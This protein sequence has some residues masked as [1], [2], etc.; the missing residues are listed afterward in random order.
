MEIKQ[1][2]ERQESDLKSLFRF[3]DICIFV[4]TF[5]YVE[6]RLDKK[7]KVNFKIYDIT[8][9]RTNNYNR[10]ITEYLKK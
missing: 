6:K 8:N 1:F 2:F 9:W 5:G 3:S 4:L 10:H 7:G